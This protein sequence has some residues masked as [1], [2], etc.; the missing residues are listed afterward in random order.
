MKRL[1]FLLLFS[2]SACGAD[3]APEG[4]GL[5]VSGDVQIGAVGQ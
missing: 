5:K 1:S 3:G 4:P 2:V